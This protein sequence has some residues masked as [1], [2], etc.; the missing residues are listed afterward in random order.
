MTDADGRYLDA[1]SR[2][3]ELLGVASV[4]ELRATPATEFQPFPVDP[5]EEQA[6]REAFTTAAA[7][8]LFGE[9]AIRRLDGEL[10]R[11]R[12]AIIPEGAGY[13]VLLYPVERPTSNLV[14]RVYRIADVLAEWRSA[15]RRLV[16]V[17]PESDEGRQ[18]AADVEFLQQQ[19]RLMFDRS[20]EARP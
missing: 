11:V 14:A 1:D 15:E 4:E 9:A 8:G 10:V 3:L 2:A 12:T 6:F 18:V 17:D 13:R 7:R 5:L 20:W 16:R 19:Y